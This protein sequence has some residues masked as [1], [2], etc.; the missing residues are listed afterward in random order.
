MNL[1]LSK[2]L[3]SV[4]SS[5][6]GVGVTKNSYSKVSIQHTL[7]HEWW[8]KAMTD[9]RCDS[10]QNCTSSEKILVGPYGE[11]YPASHDANQAMNIKAEEDSDAEEEADPLQIAVQEVKAEPEVSCMVLY[12][13]C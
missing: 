4:E 10:L 8:C 6:H 3:K 7:F 12:D 5:C 1:T 9:K 2:I 13:H 11:I